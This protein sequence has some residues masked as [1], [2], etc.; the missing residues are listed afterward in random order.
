M[1]QP[2]YRTGAYC[3]LRFSSDQPAKSAGDLEEMEDIDQS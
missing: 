2:A 1:D 3:K